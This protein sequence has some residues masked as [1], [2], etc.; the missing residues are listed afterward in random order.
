[1]EMSI[2][3][4]PCDLDIYFSFQIDIVISHNTRVI[5]KIPNPRISGEKRRCAWIDLTVVLAFRSI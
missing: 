1:M 2:F 3:N 5:D 4:L